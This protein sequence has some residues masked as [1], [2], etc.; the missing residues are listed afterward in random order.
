M[1]GCLVP[2]N[3]DDPKMLQISVGDTAEDEEADANKC[4]L[5]AVDWKE[6][7]GK[8]ILAVS[9]CCRMRKGTTD[10]ARINERVQGRDQRGHAD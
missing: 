2:A 4:L 3:D 10:R 6:L 9:S 7:I 8:R 1:L 5:F